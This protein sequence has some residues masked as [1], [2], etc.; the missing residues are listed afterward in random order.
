MTFL[1]FLFSIRNMKKIGVSIP[2][3]Y[4]SG[5]IKI[6]ESRILKDTYGKA[7]IF[8]NYLKDLNV[9]HIELRHRKAEISE[10]DMEI[11]FKLLYDFKF[12]IT[13]HG[14]TPIHGNKWTI[15]DV[16]PWL[17]SYNEIFLHN[18]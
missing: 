8:L 4:L 15:T 2:W 17:N 9:T 3:D 7:D 14:D 18:I 10:E 6:K 12:K 5:N 16:F 1:Q 11:V 13:I